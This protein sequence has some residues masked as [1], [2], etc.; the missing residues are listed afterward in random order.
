[1]ATNK[2]IVARELSRP[3]HLLIA[4]QPTRGLMSARSIY[5]YP[6]LEKAR[7]PWQSCWFPP[8]WTRFT[9][10][11]PDR[12]HVQGHITAIIPA[13]EATKEYIGLLMAGIPQEEAKNKF[14]RNQP[15]FN[16]GGDLE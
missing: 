10:I 9:I 5:P 12:G 16:S 3:I 14:I 4:A 11:R 1:M 15:M 13:E 7:R 6:N 8:S 2:V